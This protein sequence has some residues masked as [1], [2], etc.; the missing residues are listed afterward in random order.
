MKQKITWAVIGAGNVC[1]VKSVPGMYKTEN[2]EVK[3]VMRRN[4]EK[5]KDF[6]KRHGIPQFTTNIDDILNDPDIDIVYIS[7]PPSSHCELTLKVAAAGKAVYVE[8]PMANSVEECNL[9]IDTCK[10]AN[11]PLFV[12]YYRRKLEGFLKVKEIV[13][14]GKIGDIRFVNIDMYKSPVPADFDLENNWRVFPEIAGG[15]Y[16]QD[17]ASHQ[18][19][20]LDYLFGKITEVKGIAKNQGKLYP[21]DDIVS[22]SFLFENGVVGTG[23]W[24]FTTDKS[25]EKELTTIVGSKGQLSYNSFGNPMKIEITTSAGKEIIEVEN[26]IHIQQPLIQTIVDELRGKGKCP[27]TGVTG[28]RTTYVMSKMCGE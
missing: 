11:V 4:A 19:D 28:A 20:F 24:C 3:I 25:S 5:A 8:K 15:G 27:S 22:G 21:A 12:A 7:T 23:L 10:K 14:S 1:E 9:M 26:P 6:A 18:L 16:L 17:V 13:E 2:S